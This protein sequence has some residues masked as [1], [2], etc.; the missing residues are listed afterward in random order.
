MMS[1]NP[2]PARRD[3]TGMKAAGIEHRTTPGFPVH[4]TL[5]SFFWP[6]RLRMF[7]MILVMGTIFFLSNQPGDTLHLPDLPSI[8]KFLHA[9]AYGVLAA[10]TIFA[11][12]PEQRRVK[13]FRPALTVLLFCLVYGITD[14]LHQAFVPGREPD[15]L[16]LLADTMGA[17]IVVF[18][19]RFRS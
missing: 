2:H 16:D 9:L 6:P 4:N 14:E 3:N 12:Q 1:R 8:D 15:I 17:A 19:W 18:F 10:T 5:F 7:P 13:S 11:L